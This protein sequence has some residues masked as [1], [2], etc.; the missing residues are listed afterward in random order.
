MIISCWLCKFDV[1]FKTKSFKKKDFKLIMLTECFENLKQKVD[2]K[3]TSM[4]KNNWF[5]TSY[6]EYC[7]R[8][9]GS[10]MIR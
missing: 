4:I 10:S 9:I 1:C 3:H 2:R 6:K 8:T 7:I 5:T